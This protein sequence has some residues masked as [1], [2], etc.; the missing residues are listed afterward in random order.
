[1][2][3]VQLRLHTGDIQRYAVV[4]RRFLDWDLLQQSQNGAV[5]LALTRETKVS[6]HGTGE[7]RG[8]ER[9]CHHTRFP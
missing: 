5:I 3:S 6:G 9:L 7:R 1:M 4:K 2:E 8:D